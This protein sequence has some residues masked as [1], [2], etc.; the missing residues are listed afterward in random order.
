[1]PADVNLWRSTDHTL[2]YLTRADT[3]PHR[4]EGE[5]ALL[6]GLCTDGA[7]TGSG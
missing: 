2:A 1:M 5:A 7:H 3:I 6:D 4:T